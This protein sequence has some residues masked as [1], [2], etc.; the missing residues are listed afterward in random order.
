MEA[1]KNSFVAVPSV[2]ETL[3]KDVNLAILNKR[4]ICNL[5]YQHTTKLQNAFEIRNLGSHDGVQQLTVFV[6]SLYWAQ[7]DILRGENW[8]C[9]VIP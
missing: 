9:S 2:Y 4:S 3:R 5:K 6:V 1:L 8:Y 7:Y